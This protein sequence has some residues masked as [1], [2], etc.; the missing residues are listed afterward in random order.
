VITEF[1]G[2]QVSDSRHLKLQVAR[3][4]PG[5]SVDVKFLRDGKEKTLAVNVGELP[6][7]EKL[8]KND[9]NAKDDNGTL[10]GVAVDDLNPR[11]RRELDLPADMRGALI[12]GVDSDS[13]AAESGLKAGDVIL[14]INREKVATAAD[15]VRLTE[16]AA[17]KTT[18]LKVWS[19][20]GQHF[21][22]VDENKVG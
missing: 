4:R 21:V 2:K 12:T 3:V 10:N 5:Q 20:G 6:N 17:D 7:T 9:H 15:A 13:A 14:E 1:G 19:K 8:A 18:L 11:A 16:H 22:V